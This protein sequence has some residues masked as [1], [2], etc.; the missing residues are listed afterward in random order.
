MAVVRLKE[1]QVM[2]MVGCHVRLEGLS[3]YIHV[4]RVGATTVWVGWPN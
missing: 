1:V 4:A 2:K 3:N